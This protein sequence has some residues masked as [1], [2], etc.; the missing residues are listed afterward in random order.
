MMLPTG[1]IL[2]LLRC[3]IEEDHN[4]AHCTNKKTQ[5]SEYI[6][7]A[8]F[9]F[10]YMIL[11]YPRDV[12]F[13]RVRFRPEHR[14]EARPAH[15]VPDLED[16]HVLRPSPVV[17]PEH[18]RRHVGTASHRVQHR[19]AEASD[20]IPSVDEVH[21]ERQCLDV[22]RRTLVGERY[23]RRRV[24]Y[25]IAPGSRRTDVREGEMEAIR[26]G[27]LPRLLHPRG[28]AV[29]AGITGH[30]HVSRDH[31]R[32]AQTEFENRRRVVVQSTEEFSILFNPFWDI[33]WPG[34]L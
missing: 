13:G 10:P 29:D 4:I 3:R 1:S 16:R 26:P 32:F 21:V 34:R 11:P 7:M 19:R 18:R 6:T 9:L 30:A 8:L 23:L 15:Q 14:Q 28:V 17:H 12:G 24:A 2:P 20:A 33:F 27:L 5:S 31:G 22:Q 25:R